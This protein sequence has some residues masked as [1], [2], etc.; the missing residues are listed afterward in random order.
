VQNFSLGETLAEALGMEVPYWI[1]ESEKNVK[2]QA[3]KGRF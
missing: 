1:P 2:F 3:K